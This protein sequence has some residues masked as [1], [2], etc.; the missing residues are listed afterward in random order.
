MKMFLSFYALGRS[1]PVCRFGLQL[2]KGRGNL[3]L[4]GPSPSCFLV[5][6][7]KE[8]PQHFLSM[9]LFPVALAFD[10]DYT[11]GITPPYLVYL[12]SNY[13]PCTGALIHPLWVITA[14]HCNLP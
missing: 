3:S 2:E 10:P 1:K 8:K 14:A 9:S 5:I 7:E 4:L 6:P 13:L 11:A 12:K